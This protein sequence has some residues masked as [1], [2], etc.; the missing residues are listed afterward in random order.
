MS[1]LIRSLIFH[2]LPAGSDYTI[3]YHQLKGERY[4]HVGT[5][6]FDKRNKKL[7]LADVTGLPCLWADID[8]VKEGKPQK[9][10]PNWETIREML[11]EL[12]LPSVVVQTG[13]GVHCYWVFE[14]FE[15]VSDENRQY[16]RD[17]SA[18]WQAKISEIFAGHGYVIDHTH[19]IDRIL[20]MFGS[21]DKPVMSPKYNPPRPVYLLEDTET[22]YPLHQL[23]NLCKDVKR[24][25]TSDDRADGFKLDST[26]EPPMRKLDVLLSN[27]PKFKQT[28]EQKRRDLA[29]Q[30]GSG[31]AAA[32]A[33][34]M[35]QAEWTDQEIVTTVSYW[36]EKHGFNTRSDR[37]DWYRRILSFMRIE[38]VKPKD[39]ES[40][41]NEPEDTED[42]FKNASNILGV[43]IVALEKHVH[44][45]PIFKLV[46]GDGSSVSFNGLQRMGNYRDVQLK[47]AQAL[48]RFPNLNLKNYRWIKILDA[49]LTKVTRIEYEEI[50]EYNEIM[51]WVYGYV[52][53]HST[54]NLA[55]AISGP[56][57]YV[58]ETDVY[59]HAATL[60][61]ALTYDRVTLTPLALRDKLRKFGFANETLSTKDELTDNK[62]RQARF[63]RV[64]RA[65]L[66]ER[67][68]SDL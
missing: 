58:T 68:A 2:D 27:S 32:L 42:P 48:D 38:N 35:F 29:D 37:P 30:S 43:E 11:R 7:S 47:I 46:F 23:V 59:I 31:Y 64:S 8:F 17:L 4:F 34:H 5:C 50:D 15:P 62:R 39:F 40:Y 52:F 63:W 53:K 66:T 51:N 33:V 54:N 14:E 22:R 49:M 55:A 44:D 41:Q 57:H 60:H 28:W 56:Q 20:R 26:L 12:V 25:A 10:A 18:N 21:E 1:D 19:N 61:T 9:Y 6:H 65:K 36:L 67:G 16:F 13:G 24:K 45:D 3:N